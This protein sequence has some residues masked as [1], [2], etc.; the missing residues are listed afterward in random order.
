MPVAA[1]IPLR[2]VAI[3]R[4]TNDTRSLVLASPT[5]KSLDYEAGQFLTLVFPQLQGEARR[6]Y[7][8]S[9]A[10]G[11]GEPLTIT[12]K[13]LANGTFSR[14]LHDD[15]QV[16]D[17]LYTTG[18]S[19]YFTLP[20]P[21]IATHYYFLAA[22]SGITPILALIKTLLAHHPETPVTLWYSNRTV[23]DTIFYQ[24]I[25]VLRLRHPGFQVVYFMSDAR[26][27]LQARLTKVTLGQRLLAAPD[28][29]ASL[30]YLCG[31][32]DYM[33]MA[34]ITL[35]TEGVPAPNIRRE[36]F[37]TTK[38]V[39]RTLP[40]DTDQHLVTV[41]DRQGV[42]QFAVQYPQTILQA[43]REHG[44]QLPYSCEAGRCGTCSATCVQGQVWMSYNE[45]LMDRELAQGRVLTCVGHPIGGDVQLQFP[46]PSTGI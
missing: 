11:L 13:R 12:V 24:E 22:G 28:R 35:L 5:G 3:R 1:S 43:A 44:I 31:P 2:V 32:H 42:H 46:E 23:Q 7:S 45:V 27:L 16:G 39:T 8:I 4:E 29:H 21:W 40:P 15:V 10:P 17:T 25:E 26:Q 33:Q 36:H 41:H 37:D 34:T 6:S 30:F 19:G 38:P 9:S 14:Y 18:A 20:K